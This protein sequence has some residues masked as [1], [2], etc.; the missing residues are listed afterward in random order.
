[1]PMRF[2]TILLALLFFFYTGNG[3]AQ[4]I[5]KK[6]EAAMDKGFAYSKAKNY[7]KAL[8][9]FQKVGEATKGMRTD[10]ERQIYVR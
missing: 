10:R 2:Y 7:Q 1:M 6:V 5:D 8:E 4:Q 3:Q 9:T